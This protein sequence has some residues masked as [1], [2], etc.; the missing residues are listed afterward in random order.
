[1]PFTPLT[2]PRFLPP[3]PPEDEGINW[4]GIGLGGLIGGGLGFL[5]TGF[6]PLGAAAGAALGSAA[7]TE[8]GAYALDTLGR[9]VRTLLHTGDPGQA[10]TSIYDRSQASSTEDLARDIGYE[11]TPAGE[12]R[13][14]GTAFADFGVNMGLGALT[15]PLTYLG[16][17]AMTKAGLATRGLGVKFLPEFVKMQKP[18]EEAGALAARWNTDAA[19][20]EQKIGHALPR[21]PMLPEKADEAMRQ[22]HLER[23]Q[24][25]FTHGN[26]ENLGPGMGRTF[27][28]R[29]KLGQQSILG[30]HSNPFFGESVPLLGQPSEQGLRGVQQSI[31]RGMAAGKTYEQVIAE[32][33]APNRFAEWLGG[34][35]DRWLGEGGALRS[36]GAGRYVAD[37][38]K[39]VREYLFNPDV[40]GTLAEMQ[41][42]VR[43]M[44]TADALGFTRRIEQFSAALDKAGLDLDARKDITQLA[45]TF[46]VKGEEASKRYAATNAKLAG[47]LNLA[48]MRSVEEAVKTA[49]KLS[50]DLLVFGQTGGLKIETLGR[51]QRDVAKGLDEAIAAGQVG[52]EKHLSSLAELN[53]VKALRQA[54]EEKM[55]DAWPQALNKSKA[56]EHGEDLVEYGRNK[57]LHEARAQ[58]V[59]RLKGLGLD[60]GEA[61]LAVKRL[62]DGIANDWAATEG[63]AREN[64]H[65]T[66]AGRLDDEELLRYA[67]G[68]AERRIDEVTR[69]S[70]SLM[71]PEERAKLLLT[72]EKTGIPNERAFNEAQTKAAAPV[73]QLDGQGLKWINDNIG[74]DAGD[75]LL[76]IIAKKMRDV[77]M[78]AYHAE[79]DTFLARNATPEQIA[80]LKTAMEGA[81]VR[82]ERDGKILKEYKGFG[83]SHGTGKDRNAAHEAMKLDK[84]AQLARGERTAERGGKPPRVVEVAQ[85]GRQ[86]DRADAGGMGGRAAEQGG[87]AEL[88]PAA[89]TPDAGE[90]A[91]AGRK[92]QAIRAFTP[93]KLADTDRRLRD[94]YGE[95][96]TPNQREAWNEFN[97]RITL[98]GESGKPSGPFIERVLQGNVKSAGLDEAERTTLAQFIVK[99]PHTGPKAA[100]KAAAKLT[101][102]E[103]ALFAKLRAQESQ[104]GPA[105]ALSKSDKDFLKDFAR[106]AEERGGVREG[107]KEVKGVAE[108]VFKTAAEGNDAFAEI[109]ARLDAEALAAKNKGLVEEGKA[110]LPA[111]ATKAEG[112]E[113]GE[114]RGGAGRGQG[115][116]KK[117]PIEELS[118]EVS[119]LERK[120]EQN[121]FE[122][123]MNPPKPEDQQAAAIITP[124]GQV[125]AING[126]EVE[127][128]LPSGEKV[129]V[130]WFEDLQ[131]PKPELFETTSLPEATH[132]EAI[133]FGRMPEPPAPT[134]AASG[135]SF[136]KPEVVAAAGQEG[137]ALRKML[138]D[139]L[140]LGLEH[141]Y[142]ERLPDGTRAVLP[143]ADETF[144]RQWSRYTHSIHENPA[145]AV[146]GLAPEQAAAF[147]RM[148]QWVDGGGTAPHAPK[149]GSTPQNPKFAFAE[150]WQPKGVEQAWRMTRE[151]W[152]A[153]VQAEAPTHAD[154][155]ATEA[156][157]LAAVKQALE[158]GRRI[159]GKV[160]DSFK[161]LPEYKV[162]REQNELNLTR[163]NVDQTLSV[164]DRYLQLRA[165]EEQLQAKLDASGK[166]ADRVALD[167]LI[168]EREHFQKT[169]LDEIPNHMHL[170]LTEEGKR[171]AVKLKV[172]SENK[173]NAQSFKRNMDIN[174]RPA[175]ARELNEMLVKDPER[176]AGLVGIGG[177]RPEADLDINALFRAMKDPD[178]ATLEAIGK[179]LG[180]TLPEMQKMPTL[181]RLKAFRQAYATIF[182]ERPDVLLAANLESMVKT[183]HKSD[184]VNGIA[185][186]FTRPMAALPDTPEVAASRTRLAELQKTLKEAGGSPEMQ[187][188]IE[189]EEALL[190]SHSAVP[191]G[192]VRASDLAPGNEK[193]A[194]RMMKKEAYDLAYKQLH[195]MDEPAWMRNMPKLITRSVAA[196]KYLQIGLY[197]GFYIRNVIGDVTR[198]LQANGWH[199]STT[200]E[201]FNIARVWKNWDDPEA[202]RKIS[203]QHAGKKVNGLEFQRELLDQ[204]VTGVDQV[205]QEMRAS[206]RGRTERGAIG[207]AGARAYE[208]LPG[209]LKPS[210]W[211][212]FSQNWQ[213][214]EMYHSRRAMGDTAEAAASLVNQTMFDYSI[215]SPFV[216]MARKTGAI[217]FATWASKN[218]PWQ[219]EMLMT[220]PGQF[221]AMLHAKQAVEA[222]VPG[223]DEHD[224]PGYLKDKFNVVLSKG[225][226]G[227]VWFR[228]LSGV[229]PMADLP[230]FTSVG[231]Y[232]QEALGPLPRLTVEKLTNR[233]IFT[234]RD[235]EK[236]DGELSAWQPFDDLSITARD[237]HTLK[238]VIGR[239]LTVAEQAANL[240][241]EVVDPR[242][243]RAKGFMESP[244]VVN[245]LV[246]VMPTQTV[247]GENRMRERK[248]LA[249]EAQKARSAAKR[250]QQRGDP[251]R[252]REE[253][254]K[255]LDFERQRSEVR[256]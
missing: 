109:E 140:K 223:V 227:K 130:T 42:T 222:G 147:E 149:P 116:K 241:G 35:D 160:L 105:L 150:E 68:P 21:L 81:I 249:S 75:A 201:T 7:G 177:Q 186:L 13:S 184:M 199:P 56:V 44:R 209:A 1:M 108:T 96:L 244:A 144:A 87:T 195:L 39:K 133:V 193:L 237:M 58:T 72:S 6:N 178:N 62:D 107:G 65:L 37:N 110:A 254:E 46:G 103:R 102:D 94:L 43:G 45:E 205:S 24:E 55:A 19:R 26:T 231:S 11:M 161:K 167:K 98:H 158:D 207:K 32:L 213:R 121:Q 49:R 123:S 12:N 179:K 113:L 89:A 246:G 34:V 88:R 60:D 173:L 183:L 187:A 20:I 5:A 128:T 57:G 162:L 212:D 48:Q 22:A 247:P 112:L 2:T 8:T 206:L 210:A 235:I 69:K 80:N 120:L 129:E 66:Q 224:L 63:V 117:T 232:M 3:R 23:V 40:S 78:D 204:G 61:G 73:T 115:R 90:P 252:A 104:P 15:D 153:K 17:G 53:G 52:I 229:V 124:K 95:T 16:P 111:E 30:V 189:A 172:F 219:L 83:F 71:T 25:F 251:V 50:D 67:R 142:L 170:T 145:M 141:S 84:E 240:A 18:L 157:H 253:Q 86:V 228:T 27:R 191:P 197:P 192:W 14:W 256:P 47:R 135:V 101:E 234:R 31:E 175:T 182:E 54:A 154:V 190:Q 211:M 155:A 125:T 119:K 208:K 36:T 126:D 168:A 159:P 76:R 238:A 239:P 248:V 185:N 33:P 79:G 29:L 127:F 138:P 91:Q 118:A 74:D 181:E 200:A 165:R 230:P 236:F 152:I 220:K 4:S 203:I 97:S 106:F 174:Q 51:A 250:W 215:V 243:G 245:A 100:K 166:T 82:V 132:G 10:L 70:V 196:W 122:S 176:T 64:W 59:A 214:M 217:P 85:E 242:L 143:D 28:E 41:R 139:D 136:W 171:A 134:P 180:K 225:E 233:E 148:Q 216:N 164:K 163:M 255:A 114:A 202:L 38:M 188:A 137:R 194:G 151:E 169:V 156:A 218:I 93:E 131:G 9:P 77:G 92:A 226:D 198:R 221:A 99:N 146:E